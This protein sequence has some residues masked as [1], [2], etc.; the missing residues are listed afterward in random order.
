MYPGGKKLGGTGNGSATIARPALLQSEQSGN[1]FPPRLTCR[2]RPRCHAVGPTSGRLVADMLEEQPPVKLIQTYSA[3]FSLAL[4]PSCVK[5]IEASNRLAR[6]SREKF[7]GPRAL[8]RPHRVRC[9]GGL[10]RI[11]NSDQA[12]C[13][14][15]PCYSAQS[16]MPLLLNSQQGLEPGDAHPFECDTPAVLNK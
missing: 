4:N 11:R 9:H 16:W 10:Q 2:K 12:F 13:Q 5:R 1:P 7:D 14:E 6:S 8:S 3:F 15:S